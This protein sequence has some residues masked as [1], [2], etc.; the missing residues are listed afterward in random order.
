MLKEIL[1]LKCWKF[2]KIMVLHLFLYNMVRLNEEQRIRI[3]TLLDKEVY[4]Q[5]EL[6]QKYNVSKSIIFRLYEKYKET[7]STKDLPRSGRP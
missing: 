1:M 4:T 6:A 2:K 7:K 3:C 5:P